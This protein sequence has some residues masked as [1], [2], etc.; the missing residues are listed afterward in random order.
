MCHPVAH[1][2]GL[3]GINEPH[4]AAP[5]RPQTQTPPQGARECARITASPIGE[6]RGGPRYAVGFDAISRAG[7]GLFVGIALRLGTIGAIDRRGGNIVT[8][9]PQALDFA[10]D[11]GV[12]NRRIGTDE[13]GQT[14]LNH[15]GSFAHDGHLTTVVE[16]LVTDPV[17]QY[18][19]GLNSRMLKN[20]EI[21]RMK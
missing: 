17:D 10:Q 6:R 16:L 19:G 4:D 5:R 15:R 9:S 11:K 3:N 20:G 18:E 13:V 21:W 14:G 8:E 2:G 7:F 1:H 12:R